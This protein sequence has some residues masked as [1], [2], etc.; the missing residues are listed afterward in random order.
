MGPLL[1]K[2]GVQPGDSRLLIAANQWYHVI[3]ASNGTNSA[4]YVNGVAAATGSAEA[5]SVDL[6]RSGWHVFFHLS[7]QGVIDEVKIY[8]RALTAAEAFLNTRR[9]GHSGS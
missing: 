1:C 7:V 5:A 3:Y 8:S 9:L 2:W 6:Y 4:I